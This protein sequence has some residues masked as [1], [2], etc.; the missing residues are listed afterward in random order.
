MV[1]VL[2]EGKKICFMASCSLFDIRWEWELGKK[3]MYDSANGYFCFVA[4]MPY[5]IWVPQMFALQDMAFRKKHV[6]CPW[7]NQVNVQSV[8]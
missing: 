5:L 3:E 6:M 2:S 1:E 7:E 8:F 4:F